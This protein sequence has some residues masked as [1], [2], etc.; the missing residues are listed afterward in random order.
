[1]AVEPTFVDLHCHLL[2]GIDDG[3]R[4]LTDSLALARLLVAQ[5]VR[6]VAVTPHQRGVFSSNSASEIRL[7]VDALRAVLVAEQIP[8]DIKPS[9]EWMMDSSTFDQLDSIWHELMTVGDIG[10]YALVEFPVEFPS[11]TSILARRLSDKGVKPI[12]AH[13]EKYSALMGNLDRI[14]ALMD[15]GFVIQVNADSI[16]GRGGA[17]LQYRC[18]RLIRLGLVQL[19]ASDSHHAE[20]RPPMLA[21]AYARVRRWVGSEAAD[22]LFCE[23]PRLILDAKP[24]AKLAPTSWFGRF[25]KRPK[26]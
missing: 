11:Y 2:P 7:A 9:A 3:P 21:E 19:V 10:A 24:V 17:P 12:L 20:R 13:V 6:T 25:R 4:T 26:S 8:L 1:V 15:E 23:N 16:A 22:L 18:R 5:N 14:R